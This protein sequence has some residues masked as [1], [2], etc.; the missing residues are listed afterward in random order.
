MSHVTH[1]NESCVLVRVHR[2]RA[3][4]QVNT[5]TY[6]HE[7]NHAHTHTNNTHP[8]IQRECVEDNRRKSERERGKEKEKVSNTHTDSPTQKKKDKINAANQKFVCV[9]V[10]LSLS[11]LCAQNAQECVAAHMS[12]REILCASTKDRV[13]KKSIFPRK[14]CKKTVYFQVPKA[15]ITRPN[16]SR[17]E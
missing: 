14:D 4:T 12:E 6:T 11:L 2:T 7:Q 17:H 3:H 10:F 8:H 16:P 1:M 9:S 13:Q 5:R 15:R